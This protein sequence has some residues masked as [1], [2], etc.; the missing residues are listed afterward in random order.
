MSTLL[1]GCIILSL[2]CSEEG[3]EST[4]NDESQDNILVI[5]NNRGTKQMIYF[6]SLSTILDLEDGEDLI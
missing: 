5:I 1:I 2:H 3:I 6:L 4:E